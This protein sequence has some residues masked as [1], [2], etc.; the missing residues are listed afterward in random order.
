MFSMGIGSDDMRK[1]PLFPQLAT[2]AAVVGL[3]ALLGPAAE[4]QDQPRILLKPPVLASAQG[5]ATPNPVDLDGDGIDDSAA[6]AAALA[7]EADEVAGIPTAVPIPKSRP[8][9]TD[10]VVVLH[11]KRLP[12]AEVLPDKAA[13]DLDAPVPRLSEKTPW[14]LL[15]GSEDTPNVK[16][17]ELRVLGQPVLE[18]SIASNR[19][20][21]VEPDNGTV[22]E[23]AIPVSTLPKGCVAEPTV[24]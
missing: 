20:L 10:Q 11:V 1:L 5:E 16:G 4:S 12:C 2:A 24:S 13:A 15:A 19:V 21:V 7:A 17:R 3:A 8:N 9:P 14:V 6:F 22:P 23:S 18:Q